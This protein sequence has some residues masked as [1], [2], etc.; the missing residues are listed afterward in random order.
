MSDDERLDPSYDTLWEAMQGICD[1]TETLA[2]DLA[3]SGGSKGF[4]KSETGAMLATIIGHQHSMAA[5]I[6]YLLNRVPE[7][8]PPQ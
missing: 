8:R 1:Y 2:I 4:S 6:Q 3:E 5:A 7:E